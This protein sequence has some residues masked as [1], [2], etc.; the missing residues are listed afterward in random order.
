[1][2]H[3]DPKQEDFFSTI[4]SMGSVPTRAK[5]V[6]GGQEATPKVSCKKSNNE[7]VRTR[8]PFP[9]PIQPVPISDAEAQKNRRAEKEKAE[10]RRME[11]WLPLQFAERLKVEAK[12]QKMNGQ[13]FLAYL[14]TEYFTS[15]E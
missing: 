10:L 8:R 3:N 14:V 13:E 15:N 6:A 5:P 2:K 11:T 1:M 9:N 4:D 7:S 12:S